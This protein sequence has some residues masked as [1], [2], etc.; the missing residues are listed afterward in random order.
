MTHSRQSSTSEADIAAAL[1]ADADVAVDASVLMDGV[2]R[3]A[4]RRRLRRTIGAGGGAAVAVAIAALA[5]PALL[6]GGASPGT[7]PPLSQPPSR[8]PFTG[9]CVMQTLAEPPGQPSGLP[10]VVSTMDPG[11]RYVV[12]AYGPPPDPETNSWGNQDSRLGPHLPVVWDNGV[13]KLLGVTGE[14][15]YANAV[16]VHGTVVGAMGT[17]VGGTAMSAWVDHGSTGGGWTL[18]PKPAGYVASWAIDVNER[19]EILG[20]VAVGPGGADAVTVIWSPRED[21]NYTVRTVPK[22]SQGSGYPV[23]ITADGTVIGNL[24]SGRPYVWNPDS[25]DRTLPLP[26][27]KQVGGVNQVRGEWAVGYV[28][29]D[30][31][32]SEVT[33]IALVRWHLPTGEVTVVDPAGGL[34]DGAVNSGGDIVFLDG[35]T[36]VL[37]RADQSY[38]LPRPW[39]MT[40]NA[41]AAISDDATIIAGTAG[42]AAPVLY[43]GVLWRC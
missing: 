38:G 19:G 6:G 39:D 14:R 23:A 36:G 29:E 13:P 2:M 41:V 26:A 10:M 42:V 21:G 43:R 4:R 3:G 8:G 30:G 7:V 11:G 18:L 25:T 9:D 33:E 15:V 34:S 32:G 40:T 12:G 1:H 16:N 27:G 35:A 17:T 20:E 24:H 22:P 28:A 5:L 37:R 31:P